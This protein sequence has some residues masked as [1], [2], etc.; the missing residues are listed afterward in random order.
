MV[1]A[2]PTARIEEILQQFPQIKRNALI[3]MLQAIQ[4]EF[5]FI[6]EEAI[7]LIGDSSLSAHQQGIWSCYILQPVHFFTQRFLPCGGL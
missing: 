6:S 2:E 3:P 7:S 1:M 5:G 4:D